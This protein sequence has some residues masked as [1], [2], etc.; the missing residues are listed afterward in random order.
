MI[1]S[2]ARTAVVMGKSVR[3][4]GLRERAGSRVPRNTGIDKQSAAIMR[5]P[6]FWGLGVRQYILVLHDPH[7]ISP[8]LV[9]LSAAISFRLDAYVSTVIDIGGVSLT[10]FR[11]CLRYMYTCI[12]TYMVCIHTY[13]Q[14]CIHT[15]IPLTSTYIHT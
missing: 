12:H 2:C 8:R 11:L 6:W 7:S 3:V 5:P 9:L 13:I 14:T 4:R 1:R 10:T 15:Y